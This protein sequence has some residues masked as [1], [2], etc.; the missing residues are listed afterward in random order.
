MGERR[1]SVAVV[2]VLVG[3]LLLFGG[4]KLIAWKAG[5]YVDPLSDL[6]PVGVAANVDIT[7]PD[8]IGANLTIRQGTVYEGDIAK[9]VVKGTAVVTE[10]DLNGDTLNEIVASVTLTDG[11]KY[12]FVQQ[13]F[14]TDTL[15]PF[16]GVGSV[17][18]DGTEIVTTESTGVTRWELH[19]TVSERIYGFAPIATG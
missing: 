7:P 5:S 19:E 16:F 8:V 10:V 15:T 12:Y 4:L 6:V 11:R 17:A 9:G 13:F 14:D 2:R 3:A 1:T 18:V